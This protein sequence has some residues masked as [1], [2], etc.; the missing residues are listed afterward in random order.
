MPADSVL[1]HLSSMVHVLQDADV[2]VREE[3]STMLQRILCTLHLQ[4]ETIPIEAIH[5]VGQQV[6]KYLSDERRY[7][8]RVACKLLG[9][10]DQ[11][12][13]RHGS[14]L[15]KCSKDACPEVRVAATEVLSKLQTVGNATTIDATSAGTCSA[16]TGSES[17]VSSTGNAPSTGNAH[18][19]YPA[20]I[21]GARGEVLLSE[22]SRMVKK[23][24]SASQSVAHNRPTTPTSRTLIDLWDVA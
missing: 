20:T 8:R 5:N 21:S 16:D 7:V 11:G 2:S 22:Y 3:A 4:R 15:K 1:P 23:S 10:L 14:A 17:D 13:I 12:T 18:V 9:K 24:G 6:K 19:I